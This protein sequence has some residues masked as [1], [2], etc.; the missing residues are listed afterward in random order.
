MTSAPM[1]ATAPARLCIGCMLV[2]RTGALRTGDANLS[3]IVAAYLI[4]IGILGLLPL[5]TR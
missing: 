2:M 3:L 1:A 4:P 5:F